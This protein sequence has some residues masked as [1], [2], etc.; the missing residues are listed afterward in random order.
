MKSFARLFKG[1]GCFPEQGKC[2]AKQSKG[3]LPLEEA[4]EA[5]LVQGQD[6]GSLTCRLPNSR[7]LLRIRS[8][9]KPWGFAPNP[10]AL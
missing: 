1:G 10:T 2:L 8:R 6:L 5:A 9:T 3:C 7:A 4:G